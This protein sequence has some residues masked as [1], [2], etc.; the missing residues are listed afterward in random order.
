MPPSTNSG[1]PQAEPQSRANK[2]E[3]LFVAGTNMARSI[4]T[5]RTG[6]SQA[7]QRRREEDAQRARESRARRR[8]ARAEETATQE[9]WTPGICHQ[10]GISF[11]PSRVD[12]KFC[13]NTCRSRFKRARDKELDT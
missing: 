4:P 10:C 5:S 3:G 12:Q 2:P 11:T 13:S 9:G 7:L 8:A 1:D 6:E